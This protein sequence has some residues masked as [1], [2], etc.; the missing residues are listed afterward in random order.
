[1]VQAE[2]SREEC[3]H[4]FQGQ[5]LHPKPAHSDCPDGLATQVASNVRFL[6]V[7]FDMFNS[8]GGAIQYTETIH[9]VI[10]LSSK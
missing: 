6:S 8:N 1:M 7:V 10:G 3:F 5:G 2:A 4:C 9:N